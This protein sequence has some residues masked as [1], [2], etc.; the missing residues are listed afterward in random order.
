MAALRAVVDRA[1]AERP[2]VAEVYDLRAV[3][4]PGGEF[5]ESADGVDD[6]RPDGIHLSVDGSLW[7]AE[8]LY[9][10]LLADAT[11]DRG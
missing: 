1:A 6:L 3:L 7:L 5:L 8:R 9:G 2:D 10:D 4:C 11:P